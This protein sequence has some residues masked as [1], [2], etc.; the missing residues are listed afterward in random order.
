MDW[1]PLQE[2]VFF[3]NSN[4]VVLSFPRLNGLTRIDHSIEYLILKW[5]NIIWG[6]TLKI[7]DFEPSHAIFHLPENTV[8]APWHIFQYF[9][10]TDG[11]FG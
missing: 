8:L 11:E 7:T 6:L 5:W 4:V 2:A 10:T 1:I 9:I 3:V